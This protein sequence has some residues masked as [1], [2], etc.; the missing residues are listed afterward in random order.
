MKLHTHEGTVTGIWMP[1][2]FDGEQEI[3]GKNKN[4]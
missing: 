4:S 2:Q 1:R 3:S